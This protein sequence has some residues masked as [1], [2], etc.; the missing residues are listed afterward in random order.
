MCSEIASSQRSREVIVD[1]EAQD[2]SDGLVSRVNALTDR[3]LARLG[4]SVSAAIPFRNVFANHFNNVIRRSGEDA[5]DTR[6]RD[7]A[8]NETKVR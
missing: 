3:E 5:E 1:G 6:D 8:G 7:G 4:G 2:H